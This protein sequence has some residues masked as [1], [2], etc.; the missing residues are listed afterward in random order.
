MSD[1]SAAAPS[2]TSAG[3]GAIAARRAVTVALAVYGVYH[4]RHLGL[5]SLID[6]V[7]LAIHETGHLVFAP[8]G[9]LMGFAGGT[10]LQLM[11]PAAFV[12]YFVRRGDG[13]SASAALWWV[14][15]SCANVSVYAA[16]ARAEELPLVG[17]GEHDWAYLLGRF[18]W[19]EHDQGVG[20]AFLMVAG[21]LMLAATVWGLASARS[22]GQ[23]R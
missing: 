6:G 19:L 4:L 17:G 21:T 16:D 15:Q 23:A 1:T 22:R 7:D 12:A 20:R 14:G 2:R 18:G 13:H 9:E 10:L 5:G 3:Q 11:M 8:F